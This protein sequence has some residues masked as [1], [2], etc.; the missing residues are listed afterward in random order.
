MVQALRTGDTEV[1][2]AAVELRAQLRQYPGQLAGLFKRLL[3]P[4][5]SIQEFANLALVAGSLGNS[6]A[7]N[8][9]LDALQQLRNDPERAEWL[10]YA[11]GVY[12]ERPGWDDRFSFNL[13]VP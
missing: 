12:K 1:Q 9:I 11:L 7:T 5:T 2:D 4:S 8:Q 10:I 6:Q 3:D 13:K